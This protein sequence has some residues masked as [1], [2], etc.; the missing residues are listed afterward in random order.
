MN[1]CMACYINYINQYNALHN[2]QYNVPAYQEKLKECCKVEFFQNDKIPEI[3]AHVMMA[4]VKNKMPVTLTNGSIA[5]VIKTLFDL[6]YPIKDK[7]LFASHYSTLLTKRVQTMCIS[8]SSISLFQKNDVDNALID[9]S[10]SNFLS[11]LYKNLKFSVELLKDK[12]KNFS[13]VKPMLLNKMLWK[14]EDVQFQLPASMLEMFEPSFEQ[15][16]RYTCLPLVLHGCIQ[17]KFEFP[18]SKRTYTFKMLPLHIALL[19][20]IQ[21]AEHAEMTID[22]LSKASTMPGEELLPH[23]MFLQKKNVVVTKLNAD[24]LTLYCI[25]DDFEAD[26]QLVNFF[27]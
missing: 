13:S 12:S 14:F 11:N 19:V 18:K 10:K 16:T 26:S 5:D 20:Y 24:D 3:A 27:K 8:K 21:E 9:Y 2:H 22:D 4:M 25:N 1:S 15:F 6:E 7:D 23:L 17:G